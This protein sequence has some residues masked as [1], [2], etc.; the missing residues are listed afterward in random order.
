MTASMLTGLPV[1]LMVILFIAV[2]FF[3]HYMFGSLTAHTSALLPVFLAAAMVVPGMDLKLVAI[4]MC[5]TLGIMGIITPYA[6][7]PSPI[8]YGTGF[9]KGKDFWRLGF[10][11]GVI[12]I[13]T[14]LLIGV[15]YLKWYLS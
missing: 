11:F 13:G 6:T 8:Y 9:I 14:F 15:P 3:A 5:Y 1:M 7:G 2:F 12:F 10:I 4:G